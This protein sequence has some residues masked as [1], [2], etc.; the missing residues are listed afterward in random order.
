MFK[1]GFALG[2]VAVLVVAVA[3][4]ST[5]RGDSSSSTPTTAEPGPATT[6]VPQAGTTVEGTLE[7][8]G[9]SWSYHV[10]YPAAAP[11]GPAPL[12]IGLHGGLGSGPQFEANTGFDAVAD[13][14]GFVV[15][16]PD[17]IGGVMGNQNLRTWNVGNC[18]GPAQ[19]QNIDDVAFVDALIDHLSAAM[20]IDSDRV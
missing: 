7:V 10:H 17:G 16:Y 11:D 5:R 2:L 9:R 14:N 4:C 19:Q 15:V 3:A 8:G 6:T 20:P 12:V 1:S 18:C 13:E